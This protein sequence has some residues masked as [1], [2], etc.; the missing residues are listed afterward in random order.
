MMEDFAEKLNYDLKEIP[1][2]I[3]DSLIVSSTK[4]REAISKGDMITA[5]DLLGYDFF[6]QGKIV[7][8]NKLGRT[9]GYPTANIEIADKEKIIP[10]NG[11]YAVRAMHNG[12]MYD[13]M[14]NIGIRPTLTDGLFMIEVNMFDF[15]EEI[16]GD[17]LRVYVKKYLREERKFDG[18]DTLKAQIAKDKERTL[19]ELRSQETGYRS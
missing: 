9:L 19:F 15:D 7:E 18:M 8:G 16:Y 11:I 5:N 12:K 10:A 13:G 6:F 4:I 14:M 3:V 2:H 17:E 1:E